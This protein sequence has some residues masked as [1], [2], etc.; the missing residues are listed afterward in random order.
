M[1]TRDAS[2]STCYAFN[3]LDKSNWKT[4]SFKAKNKFEDEGHWQYISDPPVPEKIIT[5]SPAASPATGTIDV[6]TNNPAYAAGVEGNAKTMH[7]IVEMVSDNQVPYIEHAKTAVEMWN[8]LRLIYEAV[9]MQ[10]MIAVQDKLSTI[11]YAGIESGPLQAHIDIILGYTISIV[12]NPHTT[13]G[14]VTPMLLEKEVRQR[15]ILAAKLCEEHA[16]KAHTEKLALAKAHEDKIAVNAVKAYVATQRGSWRGRGGRGGTGGGR[17]GSAGGDWKKNVTCYG[18]SGKG[19]IARDCPLG[20]KDQ[21]KEKLRLAQLA[22]NAIGD[23]EV[24]HPKVL[25]T[26]KTTNVLRSD[27]LF[28]D[29]GVSR[30]LTPDHSSFITYTI[31]AKPIP[32]QLGDNSEIFAIGCGTRRTHIMSPS[33]T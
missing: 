29:S 12:A 2:S 30:H 27:A 24:D 11:K 4:F 7:R 23:D 26:K 21:A 32:I 31:L 8:N 17:G 13:L 33:G 18:C 14:T 5:Q 25:L 1:G 3:L 10:S 16:L 9:G 20:A 28:V 15:G 22:Y 19:H 6:V